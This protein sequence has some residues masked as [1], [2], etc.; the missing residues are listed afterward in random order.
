MSCNWRFWAS[1]KGI[2]ARQVL[3]TPF[4]QEAQGGHEKYQ[5]LC[6]CCCQFGTLRTVASAG[7]GLTDDTAA[8]QK[9]I[10]QLTAGGKAGVLAIEPGTYVLTAMINVSASILLR[11]AGVDATTLYFPKSLSEV[12]LNSSLPLSQ[13]R[14]HFS[15]I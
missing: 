10:A 9:A 13:A 5:A 15:S 14:Q 1:F 3:H 6:T 11:G 2:T 7:D 4:A 8:L 12:H